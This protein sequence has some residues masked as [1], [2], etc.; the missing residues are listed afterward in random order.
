MS[1]T[2]G[3]WLVPESARALTPHRNPARPG[4]PWS[5]DL[6]VVHYT[7]TPWSARHPEQAGSD[8]GRQLAWLRGERGKTSTHLDVLRD[9]EAL[10]GAPLEDRTW[11]SGGSAWTSPEGTPRDDVNRR[12]IGIDLDNVGRLY[13][14]AGGVVDSYEW[15]R[16]H[17]AGSETRPD[18]R[19]APAR[20]ARAFHGGP[21]FADTST[22]LLWEAY[23]AAQMRAFLRLVVRL[24]D[25]H[26]QLADPRRWVGH[27]HIRGTKS[28]PGPAFPWPWLQAA[29]QPGFT[30][31]TVDLIDWG[32]VRGVVE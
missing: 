9:G 30:A 4:R 22:G 29:L 11:H 18:Y 23:T 31:E 19:R 2:A 3:T 10:Q 14:T 8:R 1:T 5:L 15:A 32:A 6:V 25:L 7:A 27:E 28:D 17:T 12:S 24:R 21:V 26:P 16:M 13:S 20:A